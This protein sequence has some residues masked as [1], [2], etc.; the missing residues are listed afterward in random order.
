[1]SEAPGITRSVLLPSQWI[2]ETC[3]DDPE[4]G[5]GVLI[6][7]ERVEGT[8]ISKFIMFESSQ[9]SL[10]YDQKMIEMKNL[11]SQMRFRQVVLDVEFDDKIVNMLHD[12][13]LLYASMIEEFGYGR[14]THDITRAVR[15][16]ISALLEENVARHC[17]ADIMANPQCVVSIRQKACHWTPYGSLP[18]HHNHS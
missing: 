8:L 3:S 13:I 15:S 18:V 1:M 7:V 10:M 11:F 16:A 4:D 2:L 6:H 5:H 17:F 9:R 14:I 12:A